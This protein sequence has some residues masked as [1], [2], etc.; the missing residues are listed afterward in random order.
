MFENVRKIKNKSL[1]KLKEVG[2]LRK[3]EKSRKLLPQNFWIC[4][5]TIFLTLN[6]F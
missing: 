2:D 1:R 6:F 3:N 4:F 5:N